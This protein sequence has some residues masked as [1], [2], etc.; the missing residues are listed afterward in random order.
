MLIA[1]DPE[2]TFFEDE[3]LHMLLVRRFSSCVL[4]FTTRL[5][6]S[7]G[8]EAV[9]LNSSLITLFLICLINLLDFAAETCFL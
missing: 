3:D 5:F 7:K 9:L 6:S 4:L 8:V 1:Y 2:V